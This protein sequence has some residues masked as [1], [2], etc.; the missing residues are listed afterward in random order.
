LFTGNLGRPNNG[1][2]GN[3]NK[4]DWEIWENINREIWEI[5]QIIYKLKILP[6]S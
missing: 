4:T 5:T 6:I 1:N 2:P 3:L